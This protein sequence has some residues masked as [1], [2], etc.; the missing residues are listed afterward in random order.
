MMNNNGFWNHNFIRLIMDIRHYFITYLSTITARNIILKIL[1]K[2]EV[3][4]VFEQRPSDMTNFLARITHKK[5]RWY[6]FGTGTFAHEQVR[7]Y[8][9]IIILAAVPTLK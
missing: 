4:V 2:F 5:R 6:A 3:R 7:Q 8:N 9:V 1:I